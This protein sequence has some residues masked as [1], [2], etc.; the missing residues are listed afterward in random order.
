MSLLNRS[1]NPCHEFDSM[2]QDKELALESIINACNE[3]QINVTK[4]I[5]VVLRIART[6]TVKLVI[7]DISNVKSDKIK[8][9]TDAT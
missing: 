6:K 2:L 4:S 3:Y 8:E 1:D 5:S 9:S 7:L